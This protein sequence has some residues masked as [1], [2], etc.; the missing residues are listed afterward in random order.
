MMQE[1]GGEEM[2]NWFPAERC[3][4]WENVALAELA[5][6]NAEAA[7]STARIAE[8]SA[9]RVGLHLPTALAARTRAAV[10]LARRRCGRRRES[11]RG[12]RST[13]ARQSAPGS[14]WPARAAL[15][16]QALAAADDRKAA[17]EVLREAERELDACGSVRMR[18]ETRR[19]LRKLGARSE[20]RG[21]AGAGLR[22]RGAHRARA[23]DQ[24]ADRGAPDRRADRGTA[25]PEREDDQSHIRNVFNKLGASSR[26][27][28]ARTMSESAARTTA[29]ASRR[30]PHPPGWVI[31]GL[32]AGRRGAQALAQLLPF[33]V[34]VGTTAR[35]GVAA[36]RRCDRA[37][38]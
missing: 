20:A 38:P 13:R 6:G 34:H 9:A 37:A 26:V 16:G 19:E 12:S 18:D 32:R 23:R 36:S 24:R 3:F 1:V 8:E 5:L 2:R 33:D 27:E 28:V 22:R 35:A 15:L 11:R 25:L 31:S 21:P 17:I 14:R 30:A 10:Q 7:D 29:P 4:N